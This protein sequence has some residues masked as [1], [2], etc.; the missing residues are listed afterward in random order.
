MRLTSSAFADGETIPDRYTGKGENISPPLAWEGAPDE[1]KS[2]A[3]IVED[4][5][6]PKGTFTHWTVFDIPPGT[7]SL[8]EDFSGN[9][10]QGHNDFGGDAYGGP[11]PPAGHGPHRYYFR[12]FALDTTLMLREGAGKDALRDAM[13]DHILTRAELMGM[14]EIA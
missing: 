3:L 13:K 4:P 6:A 12:L 14:Y 7:D 2:F 11:K 9:S 5:D 8:A 10:P 1:T